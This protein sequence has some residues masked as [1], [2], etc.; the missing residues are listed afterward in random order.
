M[1]EL[2]L[3]R[4][5]A[6]A[7]FLL[8][9]IGGLVHATGS[10]LACPDWPLCYGQFFPAMEGGVLFEHGHRLVALAVVVLTVLLALAT[11]RRHRDGGLRA[12]AAAAILL[13]LV[14]AALGGITVMWKLPLIVSSAHLAVSM[15]FFSTIVALAFRLAPPAADRASAPPAGLRLLAGLAAAAVYAQIV[16]GAVVRHSGSGLACGTE[17]LLCQGAVWPLGGPAQLQM[18]HRL[19]GV[20]AALLAAAAGLL[21]LRLG[22]ARA[23]AAA[24]LAPVLALVQL[25]LGAWTVWSLIAVPVVSLHLAAGALLLADSLTLYLSLGSRP[26]PA[27]AAA[28][29]AAGLV[30][31]GG[32]A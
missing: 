6:L 32:D 18:A 7:T 12:L 29:G 26:V 8:L 3:A 19:A 15:A 30:P 17:A 11:W 21:A 5:T 10:S 23:R 13:V 31:A 2:R 4:A 24:L 14:Q 28:E 16:L 9:V 22:P 1:L 27:T 20:A 25:G